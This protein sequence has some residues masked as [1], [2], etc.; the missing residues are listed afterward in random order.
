MQEVVPPNLRGRATALWYVVTGVFGQATGPTAA[1]LL[2]DYV[3]HDQ[4]ALPY[5]MAIVIIPGVLL[6]LLLSAYGASMVDAVRRTL[7]NSSSNALR[8][9]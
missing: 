3:F 2:T 8:H 4:N 5:S 9:V 1:A 7:K 6:T